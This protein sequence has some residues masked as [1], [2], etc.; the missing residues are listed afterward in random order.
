MNV[1]DQMRV[2]LLLE[3]YK[4]C[5]EKAKSL[6]NNIWQTAV[7]LGVGSVAGI[8]VAIGDFRTY[9]AL[10]PLISLIIGLLAI[11]FLI[12]WIT[13]ANRWWSIQQAVLL[14][15]RHIERQTN[16]RMNLYVQYLD[17][18]HSE[19]NENE[20]EPFQF[21][22]D[23]M[24]ESVEKPFLHARFVRELEGLKYHHRGIVPMT[25]FAMIISIAA[26]M[27]LVIM[28]SVLTIFSISYISENC[29][30]LI[31]VSSIVAFL[32]GAIFFWYRFQ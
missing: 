4:L 1:H 17:D 2:Q 21:E 9:S 25:K 29:I 12:A 7:I 30:R 27:L 5:Q 16:F 28:P 20:Q 13:F 23:S 15:M 8:A 22:Q 26:W 31:G 14:R 10:K 19:R 18:L 32:G 3:E 6:E 11:G 24:K